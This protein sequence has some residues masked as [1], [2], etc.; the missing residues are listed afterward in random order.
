MSKKA[1]FFDRDGII[2]KRK[3]DGYIT[4]KEQFIFED[5]FFNIFKTIVLQD[6]LTIVITNQQGVGKGLMSE[7][8]LLEIHT[9][10]QDILLEKTGFQFDGIYYCSDLATSGSFRRKPNPGM[11]VEAIED[12]NIDTNGSWIIGDS[13]SDVQAGKSAG[14]Q[15]ILIG[16]Y[17]PDFPNADLVYISLKQFSNTISNFKY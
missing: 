12:F 3:I 15:T 11:I 2:N 14:C 5:D 8:D 16:D 9:L 4:T 10:M 13:P 7:S 6:F 1:F 17:P